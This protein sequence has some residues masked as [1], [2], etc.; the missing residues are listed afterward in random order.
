MRLIFEGRLPGLN[1]IIAA[2]RSNRFQG[3]KQ[4]RDV[5]Q[6]LQVAWQGQVTKTYSCPVT[7]AVRFFE[8]DYRRDDDN[9]FAGLKFILDALQEMG[10]I[11]TD[12]PK[13]CH[14]TPERFVDK[15]RPR[16]EVEINEQRAK[17]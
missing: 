8:K 1:E 12:A 3:A 16:V 7:V 13:W 15:D 17:G 14:V 2:N 4:K 11:K 10:V 9:V 5:Q 6:A